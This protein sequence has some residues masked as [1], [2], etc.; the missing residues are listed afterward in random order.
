ME[1]DNTKLPSAKIKTA[2][3]LFAQIGVEVEQIGYLLICK[4]YHPWGLCINVYMARVWELYSYHKITSSAETIQELLD[5]ET[6][7]FILNTLTLFQ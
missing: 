1:H 6:Q 7:T 4:H 5:L 3:A 2:L